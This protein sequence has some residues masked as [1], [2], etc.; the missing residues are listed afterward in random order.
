VVVIG[1]GIA[2][3]VLA[4]AL[5]AK[6]LRVIV[7]ESGGEAQTTDTH[8][9]NRVIQ[10]GQLYRG[11][12]HG[13]FRALGGTSSR[14]GGA[15]IPFQPAD[16]GPHT[17]GW[18][19]AWPVELD[20]LT[21]YLPRL[22]QLFG[23]SPSP[24]EMPD[25]VDG[26]SSPDFI[27]KAAKWPPFRL[28]NVAEVFEADLASPT[29]PEVWLN[30]H[31]TSI[32]LDEVGRAGNVRVTSESGTTL[33]LTARE[34]VVA[35][36]AI[37]STRLLLSLDRQ[38]GDRLFAPTAQIGRYF[39]DHLS[40]PV[41]RIEVSDRRA[42][43]RTTGFRFEG[44]AMRNTRF[45]LAEAARHAHH[46]PGA[47]AH[48]GFRTE[49]ASGFDGLRQVLQ[50]IQM[51]KLPTLAS[52]FLLARSSGWFS[53]A[54]AARLISGRVL[55][56]DDAIFELHLVTEQKP[57]ATNRISLSST[58]ADRFGVPLAAID[59]H[60]GAEDIAAAVETA[61]VLANYWR[62]GSLSALGQLAFYPDRQWQ[63]E[64]VNGGGIY[65]P[66]GTLRVATTPA[67]GVVDGDLRAFGV[68]GLRVL[69]TA[70]FPTGGGANPTMMLMLFAL[71]MADSIAAGRGAPG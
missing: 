50:R 69:S 1:A 60:V 33:D 20:A 64:L 32:E 52:M 51:R 7:V 40:A 65:H 59:W 5:A 57:V 66:G 39:H 38:Y 29:G 10:T 17:A 24:Y 37:E 21:P 43:N 48:I 11:A 26:G 15:M 71:R 4:T 46:L 68:P 42:L 19:P 45:E 54:V 36:G 49:G 8:E 22:E 14:W 44:K 28:R 9:L 47:F 31:V 6:Q 56:P 62:M 16:L 35:A 34:V 25:L 41:A 61:S 53:R 58:E 27:V 63:D 12:E 13:R 67:E 70:T 18:G 2:G 23:L 3:C 30:A 55:P